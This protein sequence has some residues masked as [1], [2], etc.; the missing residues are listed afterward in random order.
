MRSCNSGWCSG[1]ISTSGERCEKRATRVEYRTGEYCSSPE[2]PRGP[3]P[4][5][6]LPPLRAPPLI[7]ASDGVNWVT[8]KKK[9]NLF[10]PFRSNGR[11]RCTHHHA[12]MMHAAPVCVAPALCRPRDLCLSVMHVPAAACIHN[13]WQP[14][15]VRGSPSMRHKGNA[16]ALRG[17]RSTRTEGGDQR[18][19]WELIQALQES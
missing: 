5:Q 11:Q 12:I 2:G 7:D 14:G 17:R 6:P 8:R 4:A 3:V 1:G 10:A 16:H 9:R 19:P 13:S 15:G 18:A